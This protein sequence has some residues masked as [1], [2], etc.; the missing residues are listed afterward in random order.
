MLLMCLSYTDIKTSCIKHQ[1]SSVL[2]K[3]CIQ[4][5]FIDS[6]LSNLVI[7]KLSIGDFSKIISI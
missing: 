2:E 1:Q 4:H 6:A 5:I 7:V 3:M